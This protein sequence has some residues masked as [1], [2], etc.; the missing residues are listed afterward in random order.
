MEV[1]CVSWSY[2]N[3]RK[4]IRSRNIN[5][6]KLLPISTPESHRIFVSVS[7]VKYTQSVEQLFKYK[8]SILMKRIFHAK[9]LIILFADC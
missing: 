5:L 1:H 3:K 9:Y 4:S 7:F 6:H 8:L 2:N